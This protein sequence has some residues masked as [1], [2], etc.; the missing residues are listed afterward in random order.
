MGANT[1]NHYPI[2]HSGTITAGNVAQQLMGANPKRSGFLIQNNSAD[3]MWINDCGAAA[4]EGGSS[5]KVAA[6]TTYVSPIN[7][8]PFYPIS[9][10]GTTAGDAFAAREW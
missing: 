10:I 5:I 9:I 7:Q 3:P 8:D 6:G 4:A 2:D 1:G